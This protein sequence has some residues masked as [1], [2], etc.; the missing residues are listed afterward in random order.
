MNDEYCIHPDDP[1]PEVVRAA[2]EA[3]ARQYPVPLGMGWSLAWDRDGSRDPVLDRVVGV[4]ASAPGSSGERDFEPF[5]LTE[6]PAA[7]R[8]LVELVDAYRQALQSGVRHAVRVHAAVAV[9]VL[10]SPSRAAELASWYGL[11]WVRADMPDKE[12][13]HQPG[14]FEFTGTP[15][16]IAALLRGVSA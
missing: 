10:P 5:P 15:A 2:T 11:N 13:V 16:A 1:D 9:L 3:K 12:Q 7:F 6:D 8:D 14:P 4:P